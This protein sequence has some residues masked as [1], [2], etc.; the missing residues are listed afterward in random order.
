MTSIGSQVSR[1]IAIVLRRASSVSS[2]AS[3][4]PRKKPLTAEE[5]EAWSVRRQEARARLK[6]EADFSPW[7]M[8]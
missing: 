7:I 3:E 1:S 4:A 2:A 5:A 6:A 8:N